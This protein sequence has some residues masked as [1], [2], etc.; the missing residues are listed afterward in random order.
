MSEINLILDDF[1]KPLRELTEEIE[2]EKTID[3][4]DSRLLEYPFVY[5]GMTEEEYH[6]EKA[7]WGSHLKEVK[8]G[9][10]LPLWKQTRP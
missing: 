7:Y 3:E 10:Y 5:E 8:A 1:L 4:W 6:K 9:T 2:R